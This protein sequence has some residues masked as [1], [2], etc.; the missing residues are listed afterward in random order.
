MLQH[1]I[2]ARQ[3]QR[4]VVV[5]PLGAGEAALRCLELLAQTVVLVAQSGEVGR[6]TLTN[7][8][9][10]SVERYRPLL[11]AAYTVLPVASA[12]SSAMRNGVRQESY[13]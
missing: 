4:R 9:P 12:G 10:V 1:A 5:H 2:V 13:W 6:F 11:V 3:H 8:A 7:E